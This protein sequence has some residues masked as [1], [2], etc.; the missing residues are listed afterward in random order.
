MYPMRYAAPGT[1]RLDDRPP[2]AADIAPSPGAVCRIPAQQRYQ[3]S[4][5]LL[6]A[7][8]R[9]G[10]ELDPSHP[11]VRTY[12]TAAVGPGAVADLLRLI[13]A[14]RRKETIPHPLYLPVLCREGL[15]HHAG[16]AVWVRGLVPPLRRRHL[17]R[18]SP[19]LRR[20]HGRDLTA[21][22]RRLLSSSP[23]ASAPAETVKP[24]PRIDPTINNI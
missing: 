2:V 5:R 4:P 17:S 22:L 21:V 16:R 24:L 6:P 8:P 13:A 1:V 14:A 19:T 23:P 11:Y 20:N 3:I 10:L 7:A 12:W 18:L 15:V 9:K